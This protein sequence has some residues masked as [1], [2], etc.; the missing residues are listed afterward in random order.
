MKQKKIKRIIRRF[1]RLFILA[2]ILTIIV[3]FLKLLIKIIFSKKDVTNKNV[4][5][6]S[7]QNVTFEN[8]TNSINNNNENTV[9]EVI[10][11]ENS[12]I[13]YELENN[14]EKKKAKQI[15][16]WRVVLVNFQNQ[17]PS[18]FEPKLV[19]IDKYRQVDYRI[20][21]ELKAMLND[22]KRSKITN[23]WVQSAYRSV[24]HQEKVYNNSINKYMQSGETRENAEILTLKA[25]NKPG[26]SEHNLGLA[27]DLNY[28]DYD[29]DKTEAFKWLQKNAEN[30]GFVLRYK[31]EKEDITKVDY[32]PWH[33]RYVGTE[34]AIKMNELDMCLEEYVEYL[35]QN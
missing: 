4:E 35:K 34:H 17:L 6:V 18:G 33:W 22:I 30:Y 3:L 9:Y 16:D 15:D 32:E 1:V 28:V 20:I 27:I 13:Y 29:F 23:V 7:T 31:K 2:I 12:T 10:I 25:I 19:S 11:D 24:A 8:T 21:D 26:T 14:K 5:N